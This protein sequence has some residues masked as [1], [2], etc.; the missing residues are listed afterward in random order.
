MLTRCLQALWLQPVL[1]V[2]ML[3]TASTASGPVVPLPIQ[4]VQLVAVATPDKPEPTEARVKK[5]FAEIRDHWKEFVIVKTGPILHATTDSDDD[6]SNEFFADMPPLIE[7]VTQILIT[8]AHTMGCWAGG[9]RIYINWAGE[10]GAHEFGHI[11]G[12]GHSKAY[13]KGIGLVEYGDM[14]S[15]MGSGY[16][17]AT[18]PQLNYLGFVAKKPYK[19]RTTSP[20]GLRSMDTKERSAINWDKCW[21]E[22]RR[23]I[24]GTELHL[25]TSED[26]RTT[27]AM[28]PITSGKT[29]DW[30]GY[31][32]N[33]RA[34]P[35]GLA[36]VSFKEI[37]NGSRR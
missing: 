4:K 18:Y 36:Y 21:V 14:H 22:Y 28:S 19:P 35:K 23:D 10:C 16:G 15:V 24:E 37:K 32:I 27:S 5:E 6:Y 11:L 20:L 33:L 13:L 1:I 29:K 3:A 30:C 12:L 7:G 8:E 25:Y 9:T 34:N 31:S 17:P 2:S 26:K